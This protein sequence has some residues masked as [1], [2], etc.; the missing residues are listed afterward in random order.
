MP[1]YKTWEKEGGSGAA[2]K[3]S[4]RASE[5]EVAMLLMLQSRHTVS[6]RELLQILHDPRRLTTTREPRLCEG[7][8]RLVFWA[9]EVFGKR[10][11]TGNQH[12]MMS[13]QK[14]MWDRMQHGTEDL[15]WWTD[16]PEMPYHCV[17]V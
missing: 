13:L 6:F 12:A 10:S 4:R 9:F 2:E 5:K 15:M 3:V 7:L 11:S 16:R 8:K 17:T 1:S 14:A